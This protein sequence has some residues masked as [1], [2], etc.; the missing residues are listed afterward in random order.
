MI[1]IAITYTTSRLN[2]VAFHLWKVSYRW[3]QPEYH[4]GVPFSPCM[5]LE[6]D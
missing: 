2:F 6:N 3:M 4:Y 1:V 5:C